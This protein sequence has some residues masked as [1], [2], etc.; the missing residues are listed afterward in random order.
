ME[1]DRHY[2]ERKDFTVARRGYEQEEIDLHLR[3]LA[4]AITELRAQIKATPAGIAGAA[5]EQVRQI[6][7]A[8][9]ESAAEI[10][11][12]ATDEAKR[13]TDDASKRAREAR[14]RADTE[15]AEQLARVQQ[16]AAK[17]LARSS[18]LEAEL[19]QLVAGI[20]E[21][22]GT[23]VERMRGAGG[24]LEGGPRLA[25]GRAAGGPPAGAGGV[26]GRR[27]LLR[28]RSRRTARR[29]AD[30]CLAE[31][32]RARHRRLAS[33]CGGR[34]RA[35][36]AGART[37][38]RAGA[39]APTG[40]RY[41]AGGRGGRTA[42]PCR[43]SGARCERRPRGGAAGRAQHG[44]ERHSARGGCALPGGQ[45][46]AR[47]SGSD[48]RR[49][50][51]EG[52]R[53]RLSGHRVR[54]QLQHGRILR[55]TPVRAQVARVDR[56]IAERLADRRRQAVQHALEQ[57]RRL[58]ELGHVAEL[59]RDHGSLQQARV[60]L[61]RGQPVVA[62]AE[63]GAE[64]EL[65]AAALVDLH[66]HLGLAA[67]GVPP[68]VRDAGRDHQILALLEHALDAVEPDRHAAGEHP[69]A[70]G[71][72]GMEVFAEVAA[73]RPDEQMEGDRSVL[74]VLSS[75]KHDCALSRRAANDHISRS[76]AR[77]PRRFL[78]SVSFRSDA[79]ALSRVRDWRNR[80]NLRAGVRLAGHPGIAQ[81]AG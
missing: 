67:A 71:E 73:A 46:P 24:E 54:Q 13:V 74:R 37:R 16:T 19:D 49:R 29:R 56:L 1:L 6:V 42:R 11:E 45:L 69:E 39:G 78:H 9:E 10:E 60:A 66:E 43:G 79:E 80:G 51:L 68:A 35:A 47:G 62:E 23:L 61:A 65:V 27:R 58:H 17:M 38:T 12:R 53:P 64:H 3:Q 4:D 57:P 22:A 77:D 18:E 40:G 70:L 14:E 21:A 8:A 25:P 28:R 26:R 20:N 44:A 34:G 81:R 59:T 50:L 32:R 31:R 76:G 30:G 48:P 52:R 63:E 5:A 36:R 2:I 33:G 75:Q 15:S 72:G 7:E 55:G 41:G